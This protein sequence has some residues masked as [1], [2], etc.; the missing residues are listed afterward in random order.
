MCIAHWSSEILLWPA[1]GPADHFGGEKFEALRR[2][3]MVSF[4]HPRIGV[5]P[6][7]GHNA[8]N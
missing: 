3:P 5:Q 4:I 8:I 2:Y 1:S 6:W 7:I